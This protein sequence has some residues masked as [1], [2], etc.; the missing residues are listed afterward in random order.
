MSRLLIAALLLPT[1]VIAYYTIRC[2][3]WPL[4]KCGR[5]NGEGRQTRRLRHGI[6]LCR[7]CKGT[8]T[9]VRLG[10]VIVDRIRTTR[11]AER[12]VAG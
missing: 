3:Y 11:A 8:G 6:R 7:R 12:K 1:V 10:R 4:R 9:S 2:A 5:C